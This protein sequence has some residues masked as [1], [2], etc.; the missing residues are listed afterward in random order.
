[1]ADFAKLVLDADTRGLKTGEKDLQKLSRTASQVAQSV[2]G[3]MQKLGTG[4]S[5]GLTAP[6]TL[7]GKGAFQAAVDAE[8]MQSA[9]EV[10]FGDAAKSVED[11][12]DRTGD[13]FGRSKTELQEMAMSYQDIL[14]KQMDPAQAVDLSKSLTELTQDL[15]SFKNLSNDVAKQKIFSGLIGE[16]EPLRAV[17]VTLSAAKVEAKA[18]EMGLSGVNGKLTEGEKVQARAA[19]IM[20]ELADAQGDVLRTSD[21]TA[22]QIKRAQAAFQDLQ[23]V[24][25]QKLIPALSPLISKIGSALELFTSL[26]D[27]VQSTAV[28]LGMVAAAIGPLL[29]VGAPLIGFI[30]GIGSAAAASAGLG[31]VGGLAALKLGFIT[32]APYIAAFAA[33]AYLIYANWDGISAFFAE[34]G[35]GLGLLKTE[36]ENTT[37]A[38][39][40]SME[41]LTAKA[42]EAGHLTEGAAKRIQN[43]LREMGK[44][45]AV[46]PAL[47]EEIT[48]LVWQMEQA[49]QISGEQANEIRANILKAWNSE[50]ISRKK[51]DWEL[52]GEDLLKFS[53]T[54]ERFV[55]DFDAQN[56]RN[57]ASAQKFWSDF[58]A[59]ISGA[60]SAF[61]TWW[62]NVKAGSRGVVD[63]IG[64]MAK[65][66]VSWVERMVAG[67]GGAITGRLYSILGGV[68]ARIRDVNDAFAWLYNEVVGNSWVP[69]MVTEIGQHM[70]RLETELV[71]PSK[72]AT[73]AV[74]RQFEEMYYRV[75]NVLQRLFPEQQA[76]INYEKDV[77]AVRW[78]AKETGAAAERVAE[79]L[80][81]LRKEYLGIS[82][83]LDRLYPQ[84]RRLSQF[85][86]EETRLKKWAEEAGWSVE[87]LRKTL[88]DL[89]AELVSDVLPKDW[90]PFAGSPGVPTTKE[91]EKLTNAAKIAAD[92]TKTQT[93]RI[94][95]SFK[96]MAQNVSGALRDLA[97]SIKGGGFF[98]ILDAV[99]G[100]VSQLGSVG[101]FGK[102][103]AN[104]LNSPIDG[105]RANGGPVMGGKTYLV[106]ERGPELFTAP[107]TGRIIS[108]DNMSG[109]LNVTVTMD[110]S[111]GQLGAFVRNEAGQVVAR[112]APAIA[113]NGAGMALD[114]LRKANTRRLG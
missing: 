55:T 70:R 81:G 104:F 4:L 79:V 11:W 84:A 17:G 111:T 96:D 67:I 77:E 20:E 9:F 33:A 54:M 45:G 47:T 37:N 59:G 103:Y 21:S 91:F 105:A 26:P 29:A 41:N 8:E 63:A 5:V 65:S 76:L 10:T 99:V 106:G 31:T 92:K 69:D 57:R 72:K 93:V 101:V 53:N 34:I 44:S 75:G 60:W 100:L 39:G 1:M 80:S 6:L 28:M 107:R 19:V 23:I 73:D 62:E 48:E 42:V 108:N 58:G 113:Q 22:N 13:A 43:G 32:L 18:L 25:G 74:K 88:F 102:K 46:D 38:L 95:E 82:G 109:G 85:Y 89:N 97:T 90:N 68:K 3:K 61:E 86:A 64:S 35:R 24:V 78:W 49:G 12:A 30:T 71:A 16:A 51:S 15:A 66:A 98:D 36:F 94:A 40:G 112:A 83:I 27:P 52:L 114:K 50:D 110:E 2:T 7:F 14:K 87:R 56:A